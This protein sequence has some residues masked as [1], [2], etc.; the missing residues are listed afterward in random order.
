MRMLSCVLFFR[1]HFSVVF[2]SSSSSSSSICISWEKKKET[3][4]IDRSTAS[5]NKL[6]SSFLY[7]SFID[8]TPYS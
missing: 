2:F 6:W 8:D 1:L 4:M 3:D 7:S 5:Q